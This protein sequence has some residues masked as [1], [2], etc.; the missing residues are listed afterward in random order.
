[1]CYFV[2]CCVLRKSEAGN[3]KPQIPKSGYLYISTENNP[4]R[5]YVEETVFV[6]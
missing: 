3:G 4:E 1:M 2:F 6:L 5:A